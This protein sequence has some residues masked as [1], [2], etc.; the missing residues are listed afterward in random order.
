[1]PVYNSTDIISIWYSVELI[2]FR[3]L[4]VNLGAS[5]YKSISY[6]DFI[7]YSKPPMF[8]LNQSIQSRPNEYLYLLESKRWRMQD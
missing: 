1:M 5:Y 3:G 2:G 8:P 4:H 6:S 7:E